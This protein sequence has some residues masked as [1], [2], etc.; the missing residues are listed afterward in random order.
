MYVNLYSAPSY[1]PLKRSGMDHTSFNLQIHH[2]CL[3]LV[4]F[5]RRRHHWLVV[6]AIWLQLTTHFVDP[7]RMKGWANS[8]WNWHWWLASLFV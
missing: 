3:Y 2:T 4:A 6:A 5:T 1:E 7:V 8:V